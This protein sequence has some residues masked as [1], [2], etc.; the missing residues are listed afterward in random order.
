M[1]SFRQS[2]DLLFTRRFGTFCIASLLSN[3]G[4]WAQQV[5]EPWLLLS[6]GASSFVIGLDTFAT[7]APVWLLTLVGGI[8]ADRGDRRRIIATYQSIQMLCPIVIVA[9]ILT[10]TVQPWMVVVL[11]L[12]VGI[13]DALSMPSFQTIVPSI[14]ER[15]QISL[16]LALNA[17][18]FN[19]SRILGPAFAGA[20]MAGIGAV[21][22]FAAS[23]AS[24]VPFILVAIWILP[25][26]AAA[27]A[28]QAAA[29]HTF[30]GL[31]N[32]IRDPQLRGALLTVFL[33]SALCGPLIVFCPVLVRDALQGDATSFSGAISAFGLGGVL[34][35]VALLFV[36]AKRDRRRLSYWSAIV[37][38]AIVA[39]AAINPWLWSLP[40]L[41]TLAGL[42]MSISNTSANALL[43]IAATPEIRGQTVSLFMIAI[44]GGV[45]IGSFLTGISVGIIGVREALLINGVLAMVG[46]AIVGYQWITEPLPVQSAQTEPTSG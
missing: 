22:C 11:S 35:A 45:S 7:S 15:D 26:G 9:L 8:L 39:L 13:T 23:A 3:L 21:A 30:A 27:K 14:V 36:D 24:Y 17:T 42:T 10:G 25:P 37:Y 20:L 44:R 46:Y 19:L 31:A 6:L 29:D 32:I 1:S 4:T 16:G 33:T 5:V 18:Q 41:L 2:L 40:A 38:A 28:E 43:Q 34:G 12:V